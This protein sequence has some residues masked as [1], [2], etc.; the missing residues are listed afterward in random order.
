MQIK[1]YLLLSKMLII[2]IG[3]QREALKEASR[4]TGK[5]DP[6]EHTCG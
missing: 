4:T 6:E 5:K 1:A 2:N 3:K